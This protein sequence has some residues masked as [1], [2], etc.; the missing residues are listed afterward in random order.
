MDTTNPTA[1][2]PDPF[3][4]HVLPA[5]PT[6]RLP[7]AE[8]PAASRVHSVAAA[9]AARSVLY[10][11]HLAMRGPRASSSGPWFLCLCIQTSSQHLC[12]ISHVSCRCSAKVH[13]V[14]STIIQ[15][16]PVSR[17]ACLLSHQV[18]L[19]YAAASRPGYASLGANHA[20]P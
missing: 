15:P 10:C 3:R 4:S 20:A 5:G 2:S 12:A 7:P 1:P 17:T 9:A 8:V 11:V 6:A 18:T 14:E 16:C 13:L 19:Q